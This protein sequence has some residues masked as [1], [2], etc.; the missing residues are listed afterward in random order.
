MDIAKLENIVEKSKI[1]LVELVDED[2]KNNWVTLEKKY[3]SAREIIEKVENLSENSLIAL[4]NKSYGESLKIY[5]QII[6][7]I[8]LYSK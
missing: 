1:L 3:D 2:I 5:E 7:Q 6:D 4:D 8:K